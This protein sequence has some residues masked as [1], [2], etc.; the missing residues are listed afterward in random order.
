MIDES[1]AIKLATTR[2]KLEL[3]LLMNITG[4]VRQGL[5]IVEDLGI[6]FRTFDQPDLSIIFTCL[7]YGRD[8]SDSDRARYCRA[9]LRAQ[10]HWDDSDTRSFVNGSMWCP[11]SSAALFCRVAFRPARLALIACRLIET[12]EQIEIAGRKLQQAS[13]T[14]A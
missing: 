11:E 12:I 1:A 6:T 13:P 9:G 10:G 8:K 4:G 14:A 2:A 3:A 5:A 7:Q